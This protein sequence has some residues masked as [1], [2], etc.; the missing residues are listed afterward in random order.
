MEI[1]KL[2]LRCFFD[3]LKLAAF[4]GALLGAF[5]AGYRCREEEEKRMVIRTPKRPVKRR[6]SRY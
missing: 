3:L 5:V 4:G 6:R 1:T 2:W